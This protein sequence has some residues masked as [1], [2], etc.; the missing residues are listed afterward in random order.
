[1]SHQTDPIEEQLQRMTPTPPS[2]ALVERL[3]STKPAK[4]APLR[5][6]PQPQPWRWIW[7]ATATTAAVILVMGGWLWHQSA[8]PTAVLVASAPQPPPA[9]VHP[10][11]PI[12]VFVCDDI[13]GARQTGT[14][15]LPSGESVKVLHCVGV[16]R[17][18]LKN[19]GNAILDEI[20]LPMQYVLWVGI[21]S[22]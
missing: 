8:R 13:L 6:R 19:K 2:E 16:S 17:W 4:L 11:E 5:H 3:L 21:P 9:P 12:L 20:D 18:M 15:R 7:M 14:A 10:D 1:M 22:I